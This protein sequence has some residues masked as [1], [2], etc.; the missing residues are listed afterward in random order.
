VFA[1]LL[2]S[3]AENPRMK[4]LLTYGWTAETELCSGLQSLETLWTGVECVD[5]ELKP[6]Q[7]R[8]L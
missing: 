3:L 6:G 7:V 1:A 8:A 2:A 4:E 5:A